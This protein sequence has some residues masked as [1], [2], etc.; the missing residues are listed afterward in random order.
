MSEVNA[1]FLVFLHSSA[2]GQNT[3]KQS[4]IQHIN[5]NY[6]LITMKSNNNIKPCQR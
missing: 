5:S 4:F 6:N 1:A 3:N 2:K